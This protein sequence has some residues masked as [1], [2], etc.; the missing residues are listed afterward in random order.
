MPR[1][2]PANMTPEELGNAVQEAVERS[3]NAQD[4]TPQVRT[5]IGPIGS[6]AEN[7]GRERAE[8]DPANTRQH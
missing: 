5:C 4:N 3:N 2:K 8:A 6:Y 1:F 7:F